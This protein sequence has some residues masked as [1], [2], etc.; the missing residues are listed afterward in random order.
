[1]ITTPPENSDARGIAQWAHQRSVEAVELT[2]LVVGRQ[3][4]GKRET[5]GNALECDSKADGADEVRDRDWW[6]GGVETRAA[7]WKM[8]LPPDLF[9]LYKCNC[10][11]G[12]HGAGSQYTNNKTGG[13]CRL[14]VRPGTQ[15]PNPTRCPGQLS[16]H[17][18]TSL[19]LA[20]HD[21]CRWTRFPVEI[22]K[23]VV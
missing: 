16:Y 7:S 19:F 8:W 2:R 23:A 3:R 11:D 21:Y 4:H 14:F 12:R 10:P 17:S 13:S 15:P 20:S 22:S 1:V 9:R 5:T 6:V 18:R